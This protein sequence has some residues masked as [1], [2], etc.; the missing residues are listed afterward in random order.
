MWQKYPLDKQRHAM[1]TLLALLG[2]D[3]FTPQ[4]W[5]GALD[6]AVKTQQYVADQTYL[7]RKKDY[8]NPFRRMSYS[9]P[10]EMA[11]VL[12]TAEGNGFVKQV[13]KET[14]ELADRVD[15]IKR[16]G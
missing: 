10:E 14:Q 1:A 11:A 12:G 6:E 9:T 15:E 2:A 5:A 7:S 3:N 8:D 4:A 13:R 16:R